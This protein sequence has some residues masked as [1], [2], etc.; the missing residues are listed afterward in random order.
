MSTED[1]NGPD[2]RLRMELARLPRELAPPKDL[3]ARVV[4]ELRE[5]DLL[6]AGRSWP[7][8]WR[9]GGALAACLAL[10]LV[11]FWLGRHRG[12]LGRPLSAPSYVLMMREGAVFNR[13]G[14]TEARLIGEMADWAH[15]RLG[16]G[17]FVLGEKLDRDGWI[18]TPSRVGEMTALDLQDA[19]GGLFVIHAASDEEALAIA[20]SCPI[21]KHGG[22][23]ELRRIHP[24]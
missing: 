6:A 21:L 16:V 8:L 11:G 7:N 2:E 3:E 24:T 19:A 18:V 10:L 13:E 15:Q 23:V 5:R 4:A 9:L 1:D 12:R 22:S 17:R 14:W 20:G